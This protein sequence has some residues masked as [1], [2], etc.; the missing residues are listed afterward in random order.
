MIRKSRTRIS[1][2]LL[3]AMLLGLACISGSALAAECESLAQAGEQSKATSVSVHC[4]NTPSATFDADGLLWV[5]YV[6]N[7]HVW[8]SQSADLGKTYSEP[9][10]VNQD[11]EDAEHN[12][13]NRPKIIV[14]DNGFIYVSW[15]RKTSPRFTGE[16]RFSRSTDGGKSFET[17]RIINDDE[18]FTGHRFESLFLTESGH[19]YITWIDKRDLVA[20]TEKGE[21]YVGAAV[22]YSVSDDRGESF[23]ANYRVA[24]N[25]CECCR[26]AIAPRGPENIAILWRQV[27]GADVRDHAIAVLTPG[28]EM[29][30]SH[31]ASYDEWHID[32]C[33]HHG[34]TMVQSS[35][36]GDYH[37]SWFTNGDLHQGIYYA[38]YSF[39]DNMPQDVYQVDST[40]GAGHAFL[41]E[42]EETLYLIWKGF[43]GSQSMIQ[44]IES[45]DD[46]KSWSTTKTL[47]TTAAGSDHPLIVT[48]SD[49]LY[50]SWK[51]EEH[52][53]ILESVAPG[54]NARQAGD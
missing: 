48:A 2:E 1:G 12:G 45:V 6:E 15:T 5:A 9:V 4:G 41:A 16:I 38:R 39:E 21:D 33:P 24:N 27:F 40:A 19:L 36:S 3:F 29:L 46:G 50:L 17:P 22:Y 35:I 34:P 47:M 42:Y 31:R 13:E 8:V 51:S 49:G 43:D 20:S 11:S 37:M 32:A 28:G 10:S 26:I 44:L 23:S 7:E 53:Y 52:G 54:M 30:E 14:D 18:L 25:S